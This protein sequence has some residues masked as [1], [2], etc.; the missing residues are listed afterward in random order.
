MRRVNKNRKCDIARLITASKRYECLSSEDS[1]GLEEWHHEGKHQ[2]LQKGEWEKE[3]GER[4]DKKMKEKENSGKN[5]TRI[6][7]HSI[8]QTIQGVY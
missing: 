5:N 1:N 3:K 7:F 4:G 2:N 8:M 6:K